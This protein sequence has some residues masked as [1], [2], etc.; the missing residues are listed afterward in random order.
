[1]AKKEPLDEFQIMDLLCEKWIG[2][3][4]VH[5]FDHGDVGINCYLFEKNEPV[6]KK[7]QH[8][9]GEHKVK[10]HYGPRPTAEELERRKS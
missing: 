2:E 6:E 4:G 10:F 9:A 5:G 3:G 7:I 1:M 8:Q